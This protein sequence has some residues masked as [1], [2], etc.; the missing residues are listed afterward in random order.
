[1]I[2]VDFDD[3]ARHL[4]TKIVLTQ[5]RKTEKKKKVKETPKID[6]FCLFENI[7]FLHIF[8]PD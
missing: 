3:L 4:R 1:M 8:K 7:F 2:N 6:L 5:I